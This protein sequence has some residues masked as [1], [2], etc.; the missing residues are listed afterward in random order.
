MIAMLLA[1]QIGAAA[2]PQGAALEAAPPAPG[3]LARAAGLLHVL[4][5]KACP[6][7][8]G[9]VEAS[10]AQPAALYRSGDRPP[11]ALKHWADYP[12]PRSCLVEVAP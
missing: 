12:D 11:K 7:A 9:R 2:L 4:P 1:A 8:A 10:F 6:G 3:Y 5:A